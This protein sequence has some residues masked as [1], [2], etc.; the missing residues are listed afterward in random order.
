VQSYG[1]L[2]AVE[3]AAA[4]QAWLDLTAG[5]LLTARQ[6][7]AMYQKQ[8]AKQAV[9]YLREFEDLTL[10]RV[11]LAEGEPVQALE[12]LAEVRAAAEVAGRLRTVVETCLLEARA[13]QSA[14]QAQAAVDDMAQAL[15]LAAPE[16]FVRLF[17]DEGPALV[18]P[19]RE[20]HGAAPEFARHL[21]AELAQEA[22]VPETSPAPGETDLLIEPLTDQEQEVLHLLSTG[23]SN[24]EIAEALV[25][26][27]GTA[28]WHLH[29]IYGKLGVSSRTQAVAQAQELGL[30]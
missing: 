27:V 13:H 30:L 15:Q 29:N 26:S 17:L 18:K 7:A 23:M 3:L 8:R 20:A 10:A 6:W 14:G 1:L 22:E 16:R 4:Y 25:I 2:R 12:I 11:R 21:L 19:L 5:S 24:Q 28:K 9:E